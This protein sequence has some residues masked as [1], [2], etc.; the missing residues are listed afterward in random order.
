MGQINGMAG[1]KLYAQ[2][3]NIFKIIIDDIPGQAM[4]SNSV[5]EQPADFFLFFEN[6]YII[7]E[8]GQIRSSGN[9]ART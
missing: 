2:F 8:S 9:P 1:N 3:F 4:T 7:A 5:T 6:R